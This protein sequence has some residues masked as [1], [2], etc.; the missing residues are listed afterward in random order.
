MTLA[1]GPNSKTTLWNIYF[2]SGYK[3][4]T[5]AWS[6]KKKTTNCGLYVKGVSDGGE[7]DF[8]NIIDHIC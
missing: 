4:H 2:V 8:Y 7:D 5:K 6:D 1:W 3:F